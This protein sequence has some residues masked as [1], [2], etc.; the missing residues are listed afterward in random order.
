MCL[1]NLYKCLQ[2]F[3]PKGVEEKGGIREKKGEAE[4]L[5]NVK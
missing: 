5:E 1:K 3:T 2:N 4:K